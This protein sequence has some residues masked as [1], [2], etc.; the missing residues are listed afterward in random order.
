MKLLAIILPWSILLVIAA[1]AITSWVWM[2]ENARLEST[3]AASYEAQTEA[4]ELIEADRGKI[5]ATSI[6]DIDAHNREQAAAAQ[7]IAERDNRLSTAAQAIVERDNRL[8]AAESAIARKDR[9]I[10]ERD[11]NIAEVNA[12]IAKANR[13]IQE[14]ERQ[15]NLLRTPKPTYTRYPTYTPYPTA[16]RRPWPT[17]YPTY[18]RYPTPAPTRVTLRPTS[19]PSY[20]SPTR[21]PVWKDDSVN[22]GDRVT[23]NE[24]VTVLSNGGS[25]K[26][27]ITTQNGRTFFVTAAHVVAGSAAVDIQYY[28]H[29]LKKVGRQRVVVNSPEYDVAVVEL[30]HLF[31]GYSDGWWPESVGKIRA[32]GILRGLSY[33]SPARSADDCHSV[34]EVWDS[35]LYSNPGDSGSPIISDDGEGLIG[36]LICGGNQGS[37]IVTWNDIEALL[38]R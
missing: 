32:R 27:F 8:S 12:N 6:A 5:L 23:M 2:T 18:T 34:S 38:P 28:Y 9:M 31:P 7:A 14:Q 11:A 37:Y 25:G 19:T 13:I 16:T 35:T 22:S 15:I 24:G 17:P 10:T 33:V 29:G 30:T 3:W 20:M 1:V 36:M 21:T 26:G 4:R